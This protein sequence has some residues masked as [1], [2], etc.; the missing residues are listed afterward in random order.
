MSDA[1]DRPLILVID[2]DPRMANA[3]SLLLED[4]GFSH[5]TAES[6]SAAVRALGNRLDEVRAVITDY[7]LQDGFTGIKG[8]VAVTNA[9]GRPVPTLV[10]TCFHDLA[11]TVS[12]FPVLAKPFDPNLLRQWLNYQLQRDPTCH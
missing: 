7:H 8:A 6:P 4:W 10:T 2:D 9:I 12:A 11:E 1:E 3:L 5:V